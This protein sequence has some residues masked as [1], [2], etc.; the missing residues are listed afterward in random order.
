MADRPRRHPQTL[1]V[2]GLVS[3]GSR[4]VGFFRCDQ[5]RRAAECDPFDI[6]SAEQCNDVKAQELQSAGHRSHT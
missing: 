2:P 6:R 1:V 5:T 3:E 4:R